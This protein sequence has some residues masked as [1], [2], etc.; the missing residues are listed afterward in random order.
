MPT[1]DA[2]KP[3]Q[4]FFQCTKDLAKVGAECGCFTCAASFSPTPVVAIR[5]PRSPRP[6]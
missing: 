2:V 3:S 6:M 1:S 5:R 4:S